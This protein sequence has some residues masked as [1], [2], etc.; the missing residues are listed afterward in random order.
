MRLTGQQSASDFMRQGGTGVDRHTGQRSDSQKN[1]S[2]FKVMFHER[3]ARNDHGIMETPPVTWPSDFL[4]EMRWR[5]LRWNVCRFF[6]TSSLMMTMRIF[7]LGG[8]LDALITGELIGRS[9]VEGK[10]R[11]CD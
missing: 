5:A 7:N 3:V 8:A 10:T 9:V 2:T 6:F 1:G 4:L 11:K